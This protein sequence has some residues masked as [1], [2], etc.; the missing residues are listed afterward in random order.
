MVPLVNNEVY[1]I[2]NRGNASLPIFKTKFNYHRFIQSFI[3]YQHSNPPVKFSKLLN[4][5]RQEREELLNKRRKERKLLVEIIAYCLMPNHYHFI[6]R[7]IEDEGI[8]NFIRL[9][10][11]SY[12]HYFNTKY[13]RRGG[14]FEDRFKAVRIETESQLLHLSRYVHLN[15]YSSFLVKTLDKLT[16]Y[17]YSSLPE[18]LGQSEIE[19]CQKEIILS[20]FSTLKSYKQF[21]LDRADY[22]RSLEEIKLQLLED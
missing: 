2:I 18:Y 8:F 19:I 22:Q 20:S 12:S 16:K 15:P 7:Q 6:V 13:K 5:P 10:A 3:Y 11:S 21:V 17:P 9:F 4:I 14:L 1:H